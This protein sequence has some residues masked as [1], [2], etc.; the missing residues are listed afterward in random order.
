[1]LEGLTTLPENPTAGGAK[2]EEGEA[3]SVSNRWPREE[4]L[5]LLK[6]RSDVDLAFKDSDLKAPLWEIVSQ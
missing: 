4:T 5:A 1:M 2:D 6:V 3:S